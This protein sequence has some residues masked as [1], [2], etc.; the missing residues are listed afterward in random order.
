MKIFR[1]IYDKITTRN[2]I[3]YS[4]PLPSNNQAGFFIPDVIVNYT[5]KGGIKQAYS[6]KIM[7]LDS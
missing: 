4:S 7:W 1:E 2:R 5:G 6:L 3:N